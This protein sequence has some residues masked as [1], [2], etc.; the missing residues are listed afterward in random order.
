MAEKTTYYQLHQ[1]APEDDFLRTDF[2]EDFAKID[3][4]LETI[5][6]RKLLADVTVDTP[7]ERVD[8][9]LSAAD[10]R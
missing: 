4:A 10:V 2:N 5:C 9:D 7:V 8:I 6:T 3:E 1:W